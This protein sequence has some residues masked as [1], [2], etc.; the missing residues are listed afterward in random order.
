MKTIF[1]RHGRVRERKLKKITD[2]RKHETF[3]NKKTGQLY[4]RKC[5]SVGYLTSSINKF[6]VVI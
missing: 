4:A 2:Q 1:D 3:I 5:S 6:I